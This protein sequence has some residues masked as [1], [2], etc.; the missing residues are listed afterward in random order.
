M[1]KCCVRY[2]LTAREEAAANHLWLWRV[3]T[4]CSM[5]L[6]KTAFAYLFCIPEVIWGMSDGYNVD[7]SRLLPSLGKCR[8]SGTWPIQRRE[9]CGS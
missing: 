7:C 5:F 1:Q 2:L 4:P 9:A 6:A 8:S 3:H